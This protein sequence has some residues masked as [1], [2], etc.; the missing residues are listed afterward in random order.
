[1]SRRRTYGE[2]M[3]IWEEEEDKKYWRRRYEEAI[4]SGNYPRIKEL[5]KEA[6]LFGYEIPKSNDS[7]VNEILKKLLTKR[8]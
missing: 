8:K 4:H 6:L 7:K 3:A 1:M 5:Q 2:S